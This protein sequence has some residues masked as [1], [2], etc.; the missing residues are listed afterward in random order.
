MMPG[1]AYM[2]R[3]GRSDYFQT[4]NGLVDALIE[5]TTEFDDPGI[6][7]WEPAAGAGVLADRLIHH[8][9]TVFDSDLEPRDHIVS[10]HDFLSDSIYPPRNN[11]QIITNPPFSKFDAF[12]ARAKEA[13]DKFAFIGKMNYFGAYKRSETWVGLK[14]VYVFNR[15]VD[16]RGQIYDDGTFH[17]GGLV[18]GWFVWEKGN[19][20][21]N[22]PIGLEI[23]DVQK[24]ATRGQYK[25]GKNEAD[26]H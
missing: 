6:P 14:K 9:F 5:Q 2:H 20:W 25:G 10:Q 24:W 16:Y 11:F 17:V 7:I 19:G 13:C 4:P 15:Q 21:H 3:S 22:W 23:L 26:N 12:V 18:T 1:K 8:G